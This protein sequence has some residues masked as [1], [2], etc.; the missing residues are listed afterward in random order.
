MTRGKVK[1]REFF[2]SW[3]DGSGKRHRLKKE[4]ANPATIENLEFICKVLNRETGSKELSLKLT[5]LVTE[6]QKSG[7][8]LAKMMTA[9]LPLWNTLTRSCNAT[10][11]ITETGGAYVDLQPG[12]ALPKFGHSRTRVEEREATAVMLFYKLTVG[13]WEKLGGPCPRCGKY[14]I[15]KRANHKIYCGRKCGSLVSAEVSTRKKLN[16]DRAKKVLRAGALIQ[17]WDALKRHPTIDWKRWVHHADETITPKWL[18][19]AVNPKH[20][21]GLQ[22]P[23]EEGRN[24]KG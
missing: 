14:F 22:P 5:K 6:W 15:K 10:W 16:E 7:P 13:P 12:I 20:G 8:N 11:T 18:T 4:T 2:G 9:N 24:A 19:R 3:V 17:E 1:D 21:Y 23:K